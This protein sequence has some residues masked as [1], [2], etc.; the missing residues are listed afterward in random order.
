M[1]DSS[2]IQLIITLYWLMWLCVCD[3]PAPPPPPLNIMKHFTMC[4]IQF[5]ECRGCTVCLLRTCPS[6]YSICK[7]QHV[8][9]AVQHL[10]AVFS[11][12]LIF[13][14]MIPLIGNTV[15]RVL[16]YSVDRN[17][18]IFLCAY[19]ICDDSTN[20]EYCCESVIIFCGPQPPSSL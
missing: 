18:C 9:P 20:W 4:N 11:C 12:F 16:L 1:F 10:H 5:P 6:H 19:I 7:Q 13:F 15:V 14:V 8:I 17:P 2:N 3:K